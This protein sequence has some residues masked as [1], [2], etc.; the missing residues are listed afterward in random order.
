MLF[1]SFTSHVWWGSAS[2]LLRFSV[3]ICCVTPVKTLPKFHHASFFL[4][5][6]LCLPLCTDHWCGSVHRLHWCE[7]SVFL[8]FFY[9][10]LSPFQSFSQPFFSPSLSS[11]H[12][13][14]PPQHLWLISPGCQAVFVECPFADY[15]PR[16]HVAQLNYQWLQRLHLLLRHL[17]DALFNQ[18]IATKTSMIVAHKET[19]LRYPCCPWGP[20]AMAGF[21]SVLCDVLPRKGESNTCIRELS[22]NMSYIFYSNTFFLFYT[23]SDESQVCFISFSFSSPLSPQQYRLQW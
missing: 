18:P 20:A 17:E 1:V 19:L 16:N 21:L 11:P 8:F 15:S 13:S 10:F 14:P 5:L 23:F 9:F 4:L 12:F 3:P 7:S 6:L 2:H 22:R